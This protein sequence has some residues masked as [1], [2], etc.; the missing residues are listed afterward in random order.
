MILYYDTRNYDILWYCNVVYRNAVQ[1]GMCHKQSL[2][3][4][5]VGIFKFWLS[6]LR[7]SSTL[8]R[9]FLS[10]GQQM[11]CSSH[12]LVII[13][14]NLP[15]ISSDKA[16]VGIWLKNMFIPH[17]HNPALLAFVRYWYILHYLA[18]CAL[19]DRWLQQRQ[20]PSVYQKQYFS[21]CLNLKVFEN[22]EAVCMQ[23]IA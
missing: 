16:K 15:L 17:L 13:G 10:T 20:W 18:C 6:H 8:D 2:L 3:E 11:Q 5:A 1:P 9:R 22:L 21:I 7:S 23:R 19:L 4:D 12:I 14:I